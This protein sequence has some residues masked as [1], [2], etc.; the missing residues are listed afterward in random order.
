MSKVRPREVR[1]VTCLRPQSRAL[2]CESRQFKAY[3]AR[4]TKQSENFFT[5]RIYSLVKADY[6]TGA[7]YLIN[8]VLW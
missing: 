4:R 1:S 8:K 2:G 7:K 5:S 6:D 3:T